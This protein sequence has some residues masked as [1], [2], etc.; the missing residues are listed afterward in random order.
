MDELSDKIKENIYSFL[1]DEDP[2][3]VTYN[4]KRFIDMAKPDDRYGL[5]DFLNTYSRSSGDY[6]LLQTVMRIYTRLDNY[7]GSNLREHKKQVISEEFGDS[8][9]K[10]E[11]TKENDISD[12]ETRKEPTIEEITDRVTYLLKKGKMSY[13][14]FKEMTAEEIEKTL[15]RFTPDLHDY[16]ADI[17]DYEQSDIDESFVRIK[18][19]ANYI[20]DYLPDDE[21]GKTYLGLSDE[22]LG[23]AKIWAAIY[24]CQKFQD[25]DDDD[26]R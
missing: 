25:R 1:Y 23:E 5:L 16:I 18:S 26:E 12:Q 4:V 11:E 19:Y 10:G 24:L 15:E 8:I 9:P 7:T 14:E 17:I 6:T 3:K 13:S 2:D 20:I 22:E 21:F